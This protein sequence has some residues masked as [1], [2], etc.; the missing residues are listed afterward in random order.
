MMLFHENIIK[1]L[2]LYKKYKYW[3]DIENEIIIS[4]RFSKENASKKLDLLADEIDRIWF[5]TLS[6]EDIDWINNR[7][8]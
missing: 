5:K 4:N 2:R 6:D 7:F 8:K 3:S 1:Y